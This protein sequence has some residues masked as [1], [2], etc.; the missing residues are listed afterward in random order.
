DAP[1]LA[2]AV[3]VSSFNVGI[4][5]GPWLGG[6]AIDAG[7]GYPSVAWIGAALGVTALAA[8]SLAALLHSRTSPAVPE[9]REIPS[10]L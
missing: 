9:I 10:T 6:L 8:V 1:T 5:A 7:L 2:A 3:N 4:T